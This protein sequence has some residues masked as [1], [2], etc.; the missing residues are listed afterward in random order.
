MG[1]K[2]DN[3]AVAYDDAF[4]QNEREL[5]YE[6][7]GKDMFPHRWDNCKNIYL[8]ERVNTQIE[9]YKS[10]GHEHPESV[11]KE[12]VAFFQKYLNLK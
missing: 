7:L 9:T 8:N 2:D 4:E 6:L 12:I 3:D 10:I 5:I 1:E 11:K